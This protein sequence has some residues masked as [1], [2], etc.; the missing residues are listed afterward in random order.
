MLTRTGSGTKL[1]VP[2]ILAGAG[3]MEFL[4][5]YTEQDMREMAPGLVGHTGTERDVGRG[6]ARAR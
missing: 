6:G 1:F 3:E 4:R 5:V 2:K